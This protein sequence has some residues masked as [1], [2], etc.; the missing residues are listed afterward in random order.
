[1]IADGDALACIQDGPNG[2]EQ[3]LRGHCIV[4]R[5]PTV[6]PGDGMT[7]F[8]KHLCVWSTDLNTPAVQLLRAVGKP[9]ADRPCFFRNIKNCLVFPCKGTSL[10][11]QLRFRIE[12]ADMSAKGTRS[13]PSGLAGGDLDGYVLNTIHSSRVLQRSTPS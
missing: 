10:I 8:G 13:I 7:C 9:P 12:A 1:M 6:H 2:E 11:M 4:S 5:N 3:Y